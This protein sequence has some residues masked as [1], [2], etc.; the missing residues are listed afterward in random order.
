MLAR[1]LPGAPRSTIME[2]EQ[3]LDR[4]TAKWDLGRIFLCS[5]V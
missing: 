5:E 1:V 4:V 2:G 3:Y